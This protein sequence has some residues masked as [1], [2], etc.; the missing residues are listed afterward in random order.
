MD[1]KSK[2]IYP[3]WVDENEIINQV[4]NEIIKEGGRLPYSYVVNPSHS[5][6]VQH[7]MKHIIEK[8]KK[9]RLIHIPVTTEEFIEMDVD[10]SRAAKVGYRKYKRIKRWGFHFFKV[11]RVSLMLILFTL[12][13][14]LGYLA[15]LLL[16]FLKV[17]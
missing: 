12:L 4:L 7:R 16:H 8:M 15:Y 1:S 6:E 10:G 9:E 5:I 11:N 17:V 3:N 14:L 2:G 13:I